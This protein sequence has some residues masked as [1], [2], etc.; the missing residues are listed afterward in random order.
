MQIDHKTTDTNQ[1]KAPNPL[2]TGG[3]LMPGTD[4]AVWPEIECQINVFLSVAVV[5]SPQAGYKEDIRVS[6]MAWCRE[7]FASIGAENAVG[8]SREFGLE[9]AVTFTST[10]YRKLPCANYVTVE[11]DKSVRW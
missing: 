4:L 7:Q 5:L 1:S 3:Y 2:V 6:M 11:I 9:T 10:T 8:G